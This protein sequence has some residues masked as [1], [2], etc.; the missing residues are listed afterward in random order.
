MF[1]I[2]KM[3]ILD[4]FFRD[5]F[6]LGEDILGR[7]IDDELCYDEWFLFLSIELIL[8]GVFIVWLYFELWYEMFIFDCN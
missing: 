5:R 1:F 4:F 3:W 8:G 6:F 7:L 2:I